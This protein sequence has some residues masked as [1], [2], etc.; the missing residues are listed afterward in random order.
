[1]MKQRIGILSGTFDPVHRGHVEFALEAITSAKLD[2][3]YFMVERRPRRK[4]GVKA[5]EHRQAMVQLAI[6]DEPMLGSIITEQERFTPQTTLSLLK[7]R[8]GSAELYLLMGDDM[9]NHLAEWPN[10]D[11]LLKAV[12]FII[13][14]RH[15][16]A[17]AEER[18][19]VIQATRGIKFEYKLFDSQQKTTSSSSI[20]RKL[21]G[22]DKPKQL[23]DDVYEYIISENLYSSEF[24]SSET[25]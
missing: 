24:S 16:Q 25:N 15:D 19:R 12:K 3:V 23:D 11:T 2:R 21:R 20:R 10:V 9:L 17:K 8:F 13:G 6:K 14:V 22:G 1:M 5:F 7:S 18:I 4:Q